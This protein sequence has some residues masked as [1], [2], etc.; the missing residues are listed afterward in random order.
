M[1]STELGAKLH[2]EE[3]LVFIFG[4]VLF[5]IADSAKETSRQGDNVILS[6][7]ELTPIPGEREEILELLRFSVDRLLGRPGC[8][9]SGVYEAGD[10]KQTILYLE[11]W[12]SE[13]ALNL[14]VQ[15]NLYLG[16]LNAMDLAMEPREI[17]FYEISET[18]S[19]ELI[20]AL[21]TASVG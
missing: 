1:A 15:S 8:L 17:N 12:E 18:K 5:S 7:I 6:L 4:G 19:M 2:R 13:E 21:R 3:G 16:V 9:S 10:D 11:R 14:H 20:V